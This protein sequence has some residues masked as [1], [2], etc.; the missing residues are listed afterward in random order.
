MET[1]TSKIN[2]NTFFVGM[3]LCAVIVGMGMLRGRQ[4]REARAE[5]SRNQ[6]RMVELLEEVLKGQQELQKRLPQQERRDRQP[7]STPRRMRKQASEV[8]AD[9]QLPAGKE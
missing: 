9:T 3:T 1:P 7:S 6:K 5:S 4:M 2:L 8:Y